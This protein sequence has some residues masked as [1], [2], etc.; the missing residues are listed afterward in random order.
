MCTA[1]IRTAQILKTYK[2]L[3][4][5]L[6]LM[7]ACQ[8]LNRQKNNIKMDITDTG[9]GLDSSGSGYSSVVLL[10]IGKLLTR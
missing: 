7:T 1:S 4:R 2:I 6:E 10:W 8:T 9:Y 5:K 3:V